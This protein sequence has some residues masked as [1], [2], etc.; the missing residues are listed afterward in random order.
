MMMSTL[1]YTIQH[2]HWW[3]NDD[4]YFILHHTTCSLMNEWWCLLYTTPYNTLTDERMMMSTL[5]YTI[6]HAH[7]WTNDD[8]Y[9]ILHH[10]TC[11]L[12]NEWWCLLY[13]TPYTMLIGTVNVGTNVIPLGH[14]ILTQSQ[15]PV[16]SAQLRWILH[17]A[18]K[19]QLPFFLVSGVTLGII[20][21]AD[22]IA[23]FFFM[24][25]YR[26]KM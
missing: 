20:N 19:Q 17:W 8:V 6:Q 23:I 9:F 2:A 3:T 1:Y 18:K 16:Y 5:Y 4:V 26:L 13:T 15:K 25:S 12:M 24:S 21:L 10:T 22:R 7:W 11:S 14:I